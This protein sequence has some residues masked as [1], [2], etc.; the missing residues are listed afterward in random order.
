MES[1]VAACTTTPAIVLVGNSIVFE[2]NGSGPGQSSRSRALDHRSE[3]MEV[4][5]FAAEERQHRE[6]R[7][8]K[9]RQATQGFA[10]IACVLGLN[11]Q[12]AESAAVA[13]REATLDRPHAVLAF[14]EREQSLANR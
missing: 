3:L 5:Y 11:V 12:L 14:R 1:C 7:V 10:R 8:R 4:I 9:R 2:M 6:P 13:P